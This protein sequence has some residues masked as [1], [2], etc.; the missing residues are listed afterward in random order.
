MQPDRFPKAF[1][2]DHEPPCETLNDGRS[3]T[4]DPETLELLELA[5]GS[6]PVVPPPFHSLVYLPDEV[7]PSEFPDTLRALAA[8]I[9]RHGPVSADA[10]LLLGMFVAATWI[11]DSLPVAPVI[12]LMGDGGSLSQLTECLKLC[13]RRS[14]PLGRCNYATLLT[15][16][17]ELHPTLV[18]RTAEGWKA[19]LIELV[20]GA[21]GEIWDGERVVKYKSGAI[22][23]TPNILDGVVPIDCSGTPS[24]YY[25]QLPQT[26]RA[27]LLQT[28]PPQFAYYRLRHHHSARHSSF[29]APSLGSP[30][31]RLAR[32]LGSAL[33]GYGGLQT[34]LVRIL[35]G[36]E[37]NLRAEKAYTPLSLVLEALFRAAHSGKADL[38]LFGLT[39]VV[40]AESQAQRC[41]PISAKCVGSI[42][43]KELQLNPVRRAK[44]FVLPLDPR[45]QALVHRAAYQFQIPAMEGCPSCRQFATQAPL[46]GNQAESQKSNRPNGELPLPEGSEKNVSQ[47]T[48][49]L[50]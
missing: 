30:C 23:C 8:D 44:G 45:A 17:V 18:S 37:S 50:T 14:I 31:R 24:A 33:E 2:V 10:A 43:R 35:S 15:L 47:G 41:G 32:A 26:E 28:Y 1:S 46:P 5:S 21:T 13:C 29:D 20:S 16:P 48:E 12:T 9:E 49:E 34:S 6:T 11:V 7:T 27:R 40:N 38:P 3:F 19:D 42:L 39:Q 4:I 25:G 22:L 36:V